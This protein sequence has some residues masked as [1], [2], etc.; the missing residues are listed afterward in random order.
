MSQVQIVSSALYSPDLAPSYYYLFPNLEKWLRSQSFANNKEV[1]S[2]VSGF[3]EEHNGSHY[4]LGIEAI[5]HG[6]E[7]CTE[8]RGDYVEK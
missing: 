7:K 5:E 4:K 1:E 2:A 6:W 3:F 8:L